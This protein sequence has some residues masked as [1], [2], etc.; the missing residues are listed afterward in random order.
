MC[1]RGHY[2]ILVLHT[3]KSVTSLNYGIILWILHHSVQNLLSINLKILGYDVT[4]LF[5]MGPG[6]CH[7]FCHS[8][9]IRVI[10]AIG[11]SCTTCGRMK[12]SHIFFV[13]P[14]GMRPIG[15]LRTERRITLK[16]IWNKRS[17]SLWLG[18]MWYQWCAS[19]NMVFYK[20]R[21]ISSLAER[22]LSVCTVGLS[23]S[24]RILKVQTATL[25]MNNL[26]INFM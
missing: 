9:N 10:R 23:Q 6:E 8:W 14:S 1:S 17:G 2:L 5:Y 7:N 3:K 22:L 13:R 24:E 11:E 4:S 21:W 20:K 18:F 19:V 25:C 15:D 26:E 12:N 16:W